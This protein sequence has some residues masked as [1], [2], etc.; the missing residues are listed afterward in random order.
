PG[1]DEKVD[2]RWSTA[3]LSDDGRH[4]VALA[5]SPDNEDRWFVRV[6]GDGT[7]TIVDHTHDDAWV[8]DPG[9]MGWLPDNR[10]FWFG[11]EKN[12]WAHL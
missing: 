9:F 8:Q 10:R 1:V 12:G 2:L 11:A 7:G 4:A 5:R 6:A 3:L